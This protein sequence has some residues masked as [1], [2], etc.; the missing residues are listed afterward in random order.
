MNQIYLRYLL[1]YM[2]NLVPNHTTLETKCVELANQ[3]TACKERL[4]IVEPEIQGYYKMTDFLIKN[5]G[6]P[7]NAHVNFDVLN[8]WYEN[9]LGFEPTT[10]DLPTLTAVSTTNPEPVVTTTTTTEESLDSALE[11]SVG[12]R[13]SKRT[14]TKAPEV[15]TSDAEESESDVATK[16][17]R[18]TTTKKSRTSSKRKN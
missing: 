1:S 4:A 15:P 6:L 11:D 16:S 13:R 5:F 9:H 8:S 2:T 17:T 3:L 14:K 7:P 18:K 10:L 12:T